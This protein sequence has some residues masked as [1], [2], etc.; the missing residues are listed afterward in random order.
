[1]GGFWEGKT[2]D[3][4]EKENEPEKYT[5]EWAQNWDEDKRKS[6]IELHCKKWNWKL[7]VFQKEIYKRKNRIYENGQ[8]E[9]EEEKRIAQAILE[10]GI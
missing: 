4:F 8:G 6:E 10:K 9:P 1:M 7:A 2:E 3:S 5:Q